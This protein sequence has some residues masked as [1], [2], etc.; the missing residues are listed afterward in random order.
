MMLMKHEDRTF[1]Q[2]AKQQNL[3]KS[4]YF[5]IQSNDTQPNMIVYLEIKRETNKREREK[6]IIKTFLDFFQILHED[7]KIICS[8]FS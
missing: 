6:N 1:I 3:I 2:Q 5:K 4:R 8:Y 7:Y